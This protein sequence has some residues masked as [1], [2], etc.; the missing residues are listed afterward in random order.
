MLA[1][2]AALLST[3]PTVVSLTAQS[4]LP[5]LGAYASPELRGA[6]ILWSKAVE[7]FVAGGE[8]KPTRME[9]WFEEIDA[10]GAVVTREESRLALSYVPGK[11]EPVTSIEY[12]AKD[13]KDVTLERRKKA[14]EDAAKGRNAAR[15][16]GGESSF[17]ATPLDPDQQVNV[18]LLSSRQGFRDGKAI[19]S[20]EYEQVEGK[21]SYAGILHLDAS[22]GFPLEAEY[23]F[24]KAPV[25]VNFMRTNLVYGQ[26]ASQGLMAA[27]VASVGFEAEGTLLVIKKRFRGKLRFL[28]YAN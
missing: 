19:L 10:K 21:N 8:S 13:G 27:V 2:L 24:K 26:R 11:E 18:T 1:V 25:F 14:A 6:L 5:K 12:T 17:S 4:R 15:R 28:D 23:G 7:A 16:P 3:G 22:T 9:T 20:V